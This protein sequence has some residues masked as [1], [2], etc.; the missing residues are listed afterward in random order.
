MFEF[1][2]RFFARRREHL[3]K[4]GYDYAC[5]M[6]DEHGESAARFLDMV[7]TGDKLSGQYDVFSRGI[8]TALKAYVVKIP[9]RTD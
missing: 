4:A 2:R 7:V 5:Q 3:E 8:E 9:Q 1:I 6:L